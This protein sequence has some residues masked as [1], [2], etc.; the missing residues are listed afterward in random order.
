MSDFEI[1]PQQHGEVA[2]SV[3]R[4]T[5]N[6]CVGGSIPSLATFHNSPANIQ[7]YRK[8][9]LSFNT[10]KISRMMS[11]N[12]TLVTYSGQRTLKLAE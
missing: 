1:A 5:E 10:L 11:L 3:E 4:E 9:S 8:I 12:V 6:L 2:Q 7:K